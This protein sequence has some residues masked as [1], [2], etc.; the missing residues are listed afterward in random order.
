MKKKNTQAEFTSGFFNNRYC[1]L[2]AAKLHRGLI[3][4]GSFLLTLAE[5][6]EQQEGRYTHHLIL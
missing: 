5:S 1:F 3:P 2:V 6:R 4:L